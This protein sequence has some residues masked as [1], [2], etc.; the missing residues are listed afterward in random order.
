MGDWRVSLGTRELG[1]SGTVPLPSRHFAI[2][3]EELDVRRNVSDMYREEKS[4]ASTIVRRAELEIECERSFSEY[5][6][7]TG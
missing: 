1:V 5:V 7:E 6:R 4:L 2:S 3:L